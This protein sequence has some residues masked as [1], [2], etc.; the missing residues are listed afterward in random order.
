MPNPPGC[1]SPGA[2]PAAPEPAASLPEAFFDAF[3]SG[4]TDPWGF[5]TRW[6]ERRKRSLTLAALPRERFGAA[7][8]LGCSIGVLTEEL[9]ERCDTIL[10]IDVAEEPLRLARARLDG[11]AGVTF[12]RRTLPGEW[13]GGTFDLIVLSEVGY[14]LSADALRGLLEHCRGGLA[15][16]GVLIACHWRH[17]VPE[18][19]LSGDEVHAE[20]ARLDRLERTVRHEEDDFL[21][22][23]FEPAPAASVAEREGLAP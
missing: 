23:V 20:L 13:P 21:L 18:Y 15:P 2:S 7:L 3:Y 4:S 9:A 1:A 11:R 19:P 12:E 8:E 16:D 6:Y 14:Y 22:D 10:A 17:P 5:E